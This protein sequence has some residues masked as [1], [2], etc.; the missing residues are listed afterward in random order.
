M[1]NENPNINNNKRKIAFIILNL[2]LMVYLMAGPAQRPYAYDEEKDPT[3]ALYSP[4]PFLSPELIENSLLRSHI[5]PVGNE[6]KAFMKSSAIDSEFA[7]RFPNTFIDIGEYDL[8]LFIDI[9]EGTVPAFQFINESLDMIFHFIAKNECIKSLI[10]FHYR[11][12]TLQ[13]ISDV[14][15]HAKKGL[16]LFTISANEVEVPFLKHIASDFFLLP[17]VRFRLF[18]FDYVLPVKINLIPLWHRK[19]DD[20][21]FTP[22]HERNSFY[23]FS[24]FLFDTVFVD[25]YRSSAIAIAMGLGAKEK[26]LEN[27]T[28]PSKLI[29]S[30]RHAYLNFLQ[31]RIDLVFYEFNQS[32]YINAYSHIYEIINILKYN[33]DYD[34]DASS[35]SISVPDSI[36]KH[37]K[38]YLEY[39]KY[40]PLYKYSKALLEIISYFDVNKCYFESKYFHQHLRTAENAHKSIQLKLKENEMTG[41]F[42]NKI[43]DIFIE[44]YIQTLKLP[45][46]DKAMLTENIKQFY[47]FSMIQTANIYTNFSIS[48]SDM[49]DF[50]VQSLRAK[51]LGLIIADIDNKL[52]SE[53]PIN[54]IPDIRLHTTNDFNAIIKRLPDRKYINFYIYSLENDAGNANTH[55]QGHK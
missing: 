6:L 12:I 23:I 48:I 10:D 44:Y 2:V 7:V 24:E 35:V 50:I 25:L 21:W 51:G 49:I 18:L 40:Y 55:E 28:E 42:R 14:K 33:Y 26:G 15:I 29:Y 3:P 27:I 16:S 41:D 34:K 20:T 39:D 5:I 53:N 38:K 54:G 46:L 4:S 19:H 8:L 45:D 47:H 11:D 22:I 31:K 30:N 1:N 17:F 9:P 43:N 32:D 37:I 52:H 36:Q 13:D